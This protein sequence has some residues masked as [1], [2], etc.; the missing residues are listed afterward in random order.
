MFWV[1]NT[2]LHRKCKQ[3]LLQLRTNCADASAS[4][5][6]VEKSGSGG[7]VSER[8]RLKKEVESLEQGFE[9]DLVVASALANM[10]GRC[11]SLEDARKAFS[12]I[13]YP[14]IVAWNVIIGAYAQRGELQMALQLF[15]QMQW[16]PVKPDKVT[17]VILIDACADVADLDRGK[18]LHTHIVDRG[19]ELDVVLGNALVNMYGKCKSLEDANKIFNKMPEKDVVSW[20]S[21]IAANARLGYCEV[22]LRLF[23]QMRQEGMFP[24]RITFVSILS[25]CAS[26]SLLTEGKLIHICISDLGFESDVAVSSGLVNMYSKCGS[27]EDALLVYSRMHRRNVITWNAIIAAYTQHGHQANAFQA[28]TQMQQEGLKP[29]KIT[30]V[31]LLNACSRPEALAMGKWI[32]SH[33][34]SSMLESDIIVGNALINMYARCES[35]QDASM[36]FK[37]LP[38]RDV[39][40]WNSMIVAYANHGHGKDALELFRQLEQ[41]KIGG[42]NITFSS[43]LEVC[44]NLTDLEEGRRI[45]AY[46]IDCCLQP[47]IVVENALVNMY[48]KCGSLEDAYHTFIK[49]SRRDLVSWNAMIAAFTKQEGKQALQIFGELQLEQVTLDHIS[50]VGVL[51]ACSHAG[52]VDEGCH[53]FVSISQR[54]DIELTM[55]HYGCMVDLLGRAGQLKEAEDL[56]SRMPYQP[57]AALWMALLGACKLYLD[58][59]RAKRVA[60]HLFELDPRDPSPYVLLSNIY[61]AVGKWEDVR[62]LRK[63]MLYQCPANSVI[64]TKNKDS[65]SREAI[66][67]LQTK[68]AT[69]EAFF[70]NE[71]ISI[72]ADAA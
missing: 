1:R 68:H 19:L 24:S 71:N 25:A 53:Y 39:A 47:D 51:S 14:N 34:V 22:A 41:Q 58:I 37:K 8:G 20:N 32:H 42:N 59:H 50:V 4:F 35:L 17:F 57:S 6:R 10:Y 54:C 5:S 11:E 31:S 63:L 36:V 38:N 7:L 16:T 27:L 69:E 33:I 70:S 72:C 29:N 65:N 49:M 9:Q 45:H 43:I 18:W 40:S 26:A 55:E 28:F 23:K 15:E 2:A 46:M 48:G 30:F 61:A 66:S 67:D 56:I 62:K 64:E 52:L 44:A 13:L 12:R 3:S 60:E 21:L